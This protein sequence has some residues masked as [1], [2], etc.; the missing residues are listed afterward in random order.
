MNLVDRC[1]NVPM[2]FDL[3]YEECFTNVNLPLADLVGKSDIVFQIDLSID[4]NCL[5]N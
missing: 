5:K 3:R 4:K 2:D 1:K